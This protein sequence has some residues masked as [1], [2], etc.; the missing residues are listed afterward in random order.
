MA[1]Q[2]V[3]SP[4]EHSPISRWKKGLRADRDGLVD[5][6]AIGADDGSHGA[7]CGASFAYLLLRPLLLRIAGGRRPRGRYLVVRADGAMRVVESFL[8]AGLLALGARLDEPA[9]WEVE[10]ERASRPMVSLVAVPASPNA[11]RIIVRWPIV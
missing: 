2:S 9:G 6:A 3:S 8:Q 11:L 10:R 5:G 1:H 7:V 4:S